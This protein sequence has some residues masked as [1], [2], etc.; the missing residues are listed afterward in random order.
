MFIVKYHHEYQNQLELHH[1]GSFLSLN[2]LLN[3]NKEFEGGGTFFYDGIISYLNQGEMIV[4]SGKIK[5][6][7]L[8]ITKG[9]RYILVGFISI[10]DFF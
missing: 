7:G 10:D 8:P 2:I 3:D 1:D 6:A 5:H 4:H 9:I